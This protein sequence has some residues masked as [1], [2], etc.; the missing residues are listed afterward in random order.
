MADAI[1]VK[2]IHNVSKLLFDSKRDSRFLKS[3]VLDLWIKSIQFNAF[4]CFLAP[5]SPIA[6]TELTDMV[7]NI[8]A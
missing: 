8:E 3:Y 7:S 6:I 4:L 5:S 1:F 2:A